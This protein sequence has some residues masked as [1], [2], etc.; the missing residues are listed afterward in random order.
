MDVYGRLVKLLH[1]LSVPSEN[2]K[3]I[4]INPFNTSGYRFAGR[5]WQ[6]NDHQYYEGLEKRPLLDD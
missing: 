2:G 3:L 1:D 5:L 4:C 6:R